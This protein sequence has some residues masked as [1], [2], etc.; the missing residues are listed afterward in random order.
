MSCSSFTEAKKAAA[1][2][3]DAPKPVKTKDQGASGKAKDRAI[4]AKKAVLKGVHQ[5]RNRKVRTSVHFRK[6]KV[7]HLARAPKY[8]RKSTPRRNR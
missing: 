8:P 4:R 7:L 3:A 6:P 1:A 2:K 5:N